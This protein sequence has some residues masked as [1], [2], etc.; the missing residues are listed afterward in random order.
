LFYYNVGFRWDI[1][2][3]EVPDGV[4]VHASGSDYE[5]LHRK[6]LPSNYPEH[7]LLDP[8]TLLWNLNFEDAPSTCKRISTYP[9][10]SVDVPG[11]DSKEGSRRIWLSTKVEA[12]ASQNWP[13]AVPATEED[14]SRMV[15]SCVAVQREFG[16]EP[17]II[18]TPYIEN[19]ATAGMFVQWLDVAVQ[20]SSE[21]Q[22]PVLLQV[23]ISDRYLGEAP[24]DKSAVVEV[25]DQLTTREGNWGIYLLVPNDTDSDRMTNPIAVMNLLETV[26]QMAVR[27]GKLVIVNYVDLLGAVCL[28]FGATG[29]GGGYEKKGRRL[30]LD[31]YEDRGGGGA[32]PRFLS[33]T[34]LRD[35]FPREL[36]RLRDLSLL[37]RLSDQDKTR[38]SDPL[39]QRLL[40][41]GPV[42][43]VLEWVERRNN[44]AAAQQHFLQAMK[45]LDHDISSLTCSSD[46]VRFVFDWLMTAEER[47]CSFNNRCQQ[48]P[49]V[50]S[51]SHV[52]IW[53]DAVVEVARRHGLF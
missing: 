10:V 48:E 30:N 36:E 8:D 29:F 17:I 42:S 33:R 35:Y 13:P 32:F 41:G 7:R 16:A 51:S 3:S 34:T 18:P 46:K 11:Y 25:L 28:A 47:N 49:L 6:D 19:N 52:A 43:E 53:R 1:F 9:W 12:A 26:Y 2:K 22:L 39:I 40:A 23:A 44:V 21:S 14:I 4:I 5:K 37:Q 45:Q 27:Y 31:D 15:S 20:C 24:F 50:D 38:A